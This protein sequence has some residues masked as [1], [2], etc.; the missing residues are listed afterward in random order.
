MIHLLHREI[1]GI[2]TKLLEFGLLVISNYPKIVDNREVVWSTFKQ[3]AN[4]IKNLPYQQKY[5][6]L[7][8]E[9]NFSFM[10]LDGGIIQ[11]RYTVNSDGDGIASHRLAFYP[12]TNLNKYQED[13]EAYEKFLHTNYE[14]FALTD[15]Y[16]VST[17][18]R[19]DYDPVSF[20]EVV[21]PNCHLHI[22]ELEN[23]R[24]PVSSPIMPSDFINFILRNFY[25]SF[26]EINDARFSFIPSK[27]SGVCIETSEKKII[28]LSIG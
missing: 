1:E 10:F 9:N 27:R 20:V 4:L 28:H 25:S 5:S 3:N 23:C 6:E 13:P 14:Y 8:I 19:I 17:P 26:V 11:I 18:L 21:H 15:E 24:I 22:G 16:V 2:T 7:L 12:A